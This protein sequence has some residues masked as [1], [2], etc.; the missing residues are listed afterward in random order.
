M[1]DLTHEVGNLSKV[2]SLNFMYEDYDFKDINGEKFIIGKGKLINNP[3]KNKNPFD[4]PELLFSLILLVKGPQEII[5]DE[6]LMKW[7]C[8]YGM[9][10]TDNQ[11][12][13]RKF[14]QSVEWLYGLFSLW[15]A[16]FEEDQEEIKKL[17]SVVD[18]ELIVNQYLLDNKNKDETTLIKEA[19]ATAVSDGIKVN[20]QVEYNPRTKGFDYVLKSETLLSI[21]YC[22]LSGLMTKPQT[23]IKKSLKT[24]QMCNKIY[25]A[26]RSNSKYCK[27]KGCSKQNRWNKN[28]K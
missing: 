8:K 4:K 15:K 2:D 3:F 26:D 19:L 20:L 12:Y 22:Q 11:L 6:D 9:P 13:I 5:S 7:I 25:W 16:L 17:K 23:E 1:N 18:S 24:C 21:A 27:N 28:N 14:K 10:H